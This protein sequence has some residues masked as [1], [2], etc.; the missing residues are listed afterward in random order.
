MSIMT[1]VSKE[2]YNFID[3]VKKDRWISYYHQI[4]E[5]LK[6]NPSNILLIGVGDGIV[7]GIIKHSSNVECKTFDFDAELN[8]TYCGDIRNID[9]IVTETFDVIMCC[10]V[11]EHL[12]WEA[13]DETLEKL[14]KICRKKLILS[15][16]CHSYYG[17]VYLSVPGIIFK[18]FYTLKRFWYESYHF[19]YNGEHYWEV[20][21][22]DY[23]KTK[24]IHVIENYFNIIEHY[25]DY[26]NPYHWFLILE[27]RMETLSD[28]SDGMVDGKKMGRG[29]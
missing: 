28:T 13:F 22:K 27:S 24:I 6:A 14:C 26:G 16:P 1:Q 7:P 5:A 20:D 23:N 15:L 4:E 25:R 29:W 19:K 11:L 10:Q 17:M 3:Y 2:H 18:K 8:P 12:P 9:Q 21:T